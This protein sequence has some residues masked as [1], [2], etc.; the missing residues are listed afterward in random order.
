MWDG[1]ETFAGQTI[2]FD[3]DHQASDATIGHAQG[4]PLSAAQQEEIEAFEIGLFTAQVRD[5]AAGNLTAKNG[6]GGPVALFEVPFFIGINDPLGPPGGFTPVA[7]TLFDAWAQDSEKQEDGDGRS[8]ARAAVVRGQALFNTKP[9]QIDNVRG[10]NPNGPAIAGTC[11]TCHNSPDVGDHSV[12]LPLDLGLTDASRRTPDLPLYTLRSLVTGETFQTT[13]PGRALISGKFADRGRFKGP[14][15]RALASRS[16]YFHNGSAAT[17][18][19]VID[20][21]VSR[22][23]VVFTP[24]ER[25]DLVAFLLTL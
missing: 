6:R 2:H 4:A 1:R 23:G 15:L 24:Q 20:F 25:Q 13:D 12:S 3:L 19:E 21:Y 18:D 17:L 11:T 8:T 5:D 7:M 10:L 9:I 16:P 22:F 14:I